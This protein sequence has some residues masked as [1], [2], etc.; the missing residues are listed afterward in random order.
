[1][2]PHHPSLSAALPGRTGHKNFRRLQEVL[3]Q[4]PAQKPA[5]SALAPTPA[6]SYSE[7]MTTPVSGSRVLISIKRN[8]SLSIY[9]FSPHCNESLLRS[10][11]N[12]Q[13]SSSMLEQAG[14]FVPIK[15]PSGSG[16]PSLR[17]FENP[18]MINPVFLK[19]PERVYA[20]GFILVTASLLGCL[21]ELTMRNDLEARQMALPGWDNKPI[22]CPFCLHDENQVRRHTNLETAR[23]EIPQWPSFSGP[24]QIFDRPGANRG[25][26]HQ[27][28]RF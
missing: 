23:W 6:S 27:T 18:V 13:A 12:P 15:G 24:G 3:L 11:Q 5:R 28:C 21:I 1:M 10:T 26:F 14:C 4:D 22:Q 8:G 16:M 25:D 17:F 9:F 20:P 19:K 7:T 2:A